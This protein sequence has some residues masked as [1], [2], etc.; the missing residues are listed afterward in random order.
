[1]LVVVMGGSLGSG[2]LNDAV[3]EFLETHSSRVTSLFCTL[4]A[5]NG[6]WASE[7]MV[8]GRCGT[9]VASLLKKQKI[10]TPPQ[11]CSLVEVGEHRP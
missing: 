5:Y 6:E 4:Q 11:T 8:M 10:C 1:M 3:H 9:G 2:I 7:R